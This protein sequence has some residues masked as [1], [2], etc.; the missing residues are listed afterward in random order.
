M[1]NNDIYSVTVATSAL[2]LSFL[3]MILLCIII[4]ILMRKQCLSP[5]THQR[6]TVLML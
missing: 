4:I 3:E 1:I 6:V 5:E 2:L